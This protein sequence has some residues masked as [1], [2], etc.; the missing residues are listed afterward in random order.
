MG[1]KA[2]PVR[3][4]QSPSS[5]APNATRGWAK[6]GSGHQG[7]VGLGLGGL[8]WMW[9]RDAGGWWV[10]AMCHAKLPSSDLSASST[11][12]FATFSSCFPGLCEGKPAALLP[13]SLSQ[14]C[15]PVP[16]VGL[17]RI[18]PHLYLGSQKDVLNKVCVGLGAGRGGRTVGPK[19]PADPPGRQAVP[20]GVA[21]LLIPGHQAREPTY[22]TA[23]LTG[24][25]LGERIPGFRNGG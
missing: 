20:G 23:E 9:L 13:M 18:L 19:S 25:C 12:G 11:G 2:V 22:Q 3:P 15:L 10:C 5:A 14:P 16:S 7:R 1:G 24:L 21:Q 17:T 4:T 8:V 6:A